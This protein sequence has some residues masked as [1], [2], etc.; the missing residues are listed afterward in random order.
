MNSRDTR[1]PRISHATPRQL[2]STLGR[3]K[4]L[5]GIGAFIILG[6]I[7]HAVDPQATSN[8]TSSPSAAPAATVATPHKV[9]TSVAPAAT[10]AATP[11]KV[12]TSATATSRQATSARQDFPPTTLA[13]F[14][15]LAATGH[16]SEVH[17]IHVTSEGLPS[18]P[19]PTID[20]TV[21]PVLSA[22][23]L[24][25]DLAAFF[26]QH[27]LTASQCQAFVYAFHS[28]SDYQA[29]QNDGYT[30]GR[31]ALTNN[32]GSQRNL[33]VDTGSVYN[34]QTQFNFNY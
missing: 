12:S 4:V 31:V 24:Q 28:R 11:H 8:S 20:V 5:T 34:Q 26:Q 21:S 25:A 13:G 30:A 16:A 2:A 3:H 6:L 9:S 33:E 22:R 10:A 23:A 17:E 7:V 1:N 32:S 15:A 14:Q 27:G 29:H 19:T 18:C